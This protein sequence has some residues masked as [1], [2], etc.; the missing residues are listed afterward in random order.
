MEK[1]KIFKDTGKSVLSW[2]LKQEVSFIAYLAAITIIMITS[3]FAGNKNDM[4]FQIMMLLFVSLFVVGFLWD[5]M[6]MM[7]QYYGKFFGGVIFFMLSIILY[8]TYL[9]AEAMSQS[10]ISEVTGQDYTYF[11]TSISYLKGIY[12]IPALMIFL[13]KNIIFILMGLMVSLYA[14][15][16][17]PSK[18]KHLKKRFFHVSLYFSAMMIMF[19]SFI[20]LDLDK[21]YQN[22]FGKK[23][24]PKIIIHYSYH[25][26][27]SC[28]NIPKNMPICFLGNDD[29]SI[30]NKS[31]KELSELNKDQNI[32]FNVKKCERI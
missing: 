32:T 12:F 29:V 7:K 16:F 20:N 30:S 15:M 25:K 11:N 23:Y 4:F 22:I 27:T 13:G 17:I 5:S 9:Q 31:Y 2:I 14:M 24:I 28:K 18:W 3:I 1:L 19:F 8:F 26:N 21:V 10:I 6:K